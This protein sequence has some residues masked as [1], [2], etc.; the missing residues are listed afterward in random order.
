MNKYIKLYFYYIVLCISFLG[1]S[2]KIGK[3]EYNQHS[4]LDSRKKF[5]N[6]VVVDHM[7]CYGWNMQKFSFSLEYPDS[8]KLETARTDARNDNYVSFY[9]FDKDSILMESLNV[10][11]LWFKPETNF[12][13]RVRSSVAALDSFFYSAAD[14]F[15]ELDNYKL[16]YQGRKKLFGIETAQVHFEIEAKENVNN[17]LGKYKCLATYL[18]PLQTGFEGAFLI[19]VGSEH[20]AIKSFDDFDNKGIMSE[21]WKTFERIDEDSLIKEIEEK[22]LSVQKEITPFKNFRMYSVDPKKCKDNLG[23]AHFS[24]SYP[25]DSIQVDTS[26]AFITFYDKE[27]YTEYM[28]IME[29]FFPGDSSVGTLTKDYEDHISMTYHKFRGRIAKIDTIG[30]MKVGDME[31]FGMYFEYE[32]KNQFGKQGKYKVVHLNFRRKFPTTNDFTLIIEAS[33]DSEIKT[34]EDLGVKG[35]TGKIWSTFRF[36]E[37]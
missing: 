35:I 9:A 37:Y 17:F 10:G 11:Y 32:G 29:Y 20:S 34:F 22:K 5:P 8:V 30:R 23:M 15:K 31:G 12:G 27:D 28:E 3:N 1:C 18:P 24:L 36:F 13:A 2:R 26:D 21:I 4:I 33:E 14:D 6:K 25:V 7:K 19:F 16:I